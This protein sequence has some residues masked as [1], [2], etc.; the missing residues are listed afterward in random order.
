MKI[1][2][3][4][5]GTPLPEGHPLKGGSIIFGRKPPAGYKKKPEQDQNEVNTKDQTEPPSTPDKSE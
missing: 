1:T 2:R 4:P 3:H 5:A